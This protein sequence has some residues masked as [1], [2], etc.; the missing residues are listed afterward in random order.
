MFS[1]MFLVKLY[2]RSCVLQVCSYFNSYFSSIIFMPHNPLF[3][4]FTYPLGWFFCY[5]VF[6]WHPS[7]D[8]LGDPFFVLVHFHSFHNLVSLFLS[9]LFFL[10]VKKRKR[11]PSKGHFEKCA[12]TFVFKLHKSDLF[13]N[14]HR[15][16]LK[17]CI[18]LVLNVWF[19][20]CPIIPSF[21]MASNIFPSTLHTRLRLPHR[22]TCDFSWCTCI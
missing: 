9:C 16:C 14:Y 6:H 11:L 3:S 21:H 13:L 15:T 18:S 2:F 12:W 19:F 20:A 1:T 4:L 10:V 8:L 17:S 5:L 22:M 7:R